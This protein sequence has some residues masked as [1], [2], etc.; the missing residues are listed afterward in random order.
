VEVYLCGENYLYEWGEGDEEGG[1]EF[2]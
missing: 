2:G 1:F